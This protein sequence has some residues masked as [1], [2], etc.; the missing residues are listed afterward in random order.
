MVHHLNL[1]PRLECPT[2]TSLWFT[3]T[4]DTWDKYFGAALCRPNCQT[5][6]NLIRLHFIVENVTNFWI[7]TISLNN[8]K[9]HLGMTL[10]TCLASP[11]LVY[12]FISILFTQYSC[13]V[14]TRRGEVSTYVTLFLGTPCS[15]CR[16]FYPGL[17][18]TY[19]IMNE[20]NLQK[21]NFCITTS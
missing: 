17:G 11:E 18:R 12:H 20:M 14:K 7:E 15:W 4:L 1:W 19:V 2:L 21:L 8:H 3:Q 10:T 6:L 13:K 16:L 5:H 9:L